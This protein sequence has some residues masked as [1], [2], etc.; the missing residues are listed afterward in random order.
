MEGAPRFLLSEALRG[1]GA[2]LKNVR[3]E[4][5]TDELAPRDVV[6]RAIVA[7]MRRTAAPHVLLDLTHRGETFVRERFPRIYETCLKYGVNVGRDAAPVAPAVA[8]PGLPVARPP[9][10]TVEAS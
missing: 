7:E 2:V 10:G 3:G 9:L 8:G 1:E 6:A 5:F 4:R